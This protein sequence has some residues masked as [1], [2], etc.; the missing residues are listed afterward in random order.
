MPAFLLPLFLADMTKDEELTAPAKENIPRR[1]SNTEREERV[2]IIVA[3][4]PKAIRAPIII[5]TVL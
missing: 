4:P 3:N 5:A 1:R 2:R